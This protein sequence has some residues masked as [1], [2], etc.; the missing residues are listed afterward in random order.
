MKRIICAALALFIGVPAWAQGPQ[1][2]SLGGLLQNLA[3]NFGE[4]HVMT[5]ERPGKPPFWISVNDETG[6]WTVF[7]V[8]EGDPDMA[9]IVA[10][11]VGVPF[12]QPIGWAM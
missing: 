1:C 5:L 9:C 6:S 2:G 4:R 3:D 8:I 12:A 7:A 11:G 10:D